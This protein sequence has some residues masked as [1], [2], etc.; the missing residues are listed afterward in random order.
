MDYLQSRHQVWTDPDL[1]NYCYA[2]GEQSNVQ[3]MATELITASFDA[4]ANATVRHE[5]KQALFVFRSFL[6]NK[7][8]L[9]LVTMTGMMFE[10]LTAEYCITEALKDVDPQAFPSM[11][12]VSGGDD[13]FSDVRQEFLFACCLHRLIPE[14]LIA[15]LLDDPPMQ[16][17]PSGGRYVQA[18]LVRQCATEIERVERLIGEMENMDGNAGAVAGAICEVCVII[19]ALRSVSLTSSLQVIRNLAAAR[20]TLPLK[21]LCTSLARRPGALDVMLLFNRAST[22][23]Q[24]ICR[25]LDSWHYEEDQG[26]QVLGYFILSTESMRC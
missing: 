4:L 22:I 7:V 12:D 10:P 17:L 2:D 1:I 20:E 6:V 23:L 21:S 19:P 15:R 9:L 18:E 16:E 3:S 5:P 25:L 8:P 26:N 13:M 11:F 24:P 14:E